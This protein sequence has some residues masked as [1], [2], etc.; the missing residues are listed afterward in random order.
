M[1]RRTTSFRLLPALA[2]LTMLLFAAG[3]VWLFQ[4]RFSIGDIYAPYSS[5][6]ADLLGTAALHD[7]LA[8]QPGFSVRRLYGPNL[9]L[10][11]GPGCTLFVL[12]SDLKGLYADATDLADLDRFLRAGGRVVISCRPTSPS[13]FGKTAKPPVPATPKPET[14]P[15]TKPGTKPETK[16][17]T[18]SGTKPGDT[19]KE[20][21]GKKKPEVDE[22]EEMAAA[23]LNSGMKEL[24]D[25]YGF[26]FVRQPLADLGM[27]VVAE[28]AGEDLPDELAWHGIVGIEWKKASEWR[29][30]Y[31]ASHKPVIAERR[32]GNGM[33]VLLADSWHLS[34]EALSIDR[35]SDLLAWLVGTRTH[36]VL[37]EESHLGTERHEGVM[38]LIRRYRMV[39]VL[40]AFAA[41]ALLYVWR[42]AAGGLRTP[43]EAEDAL[44]VPTGQQTA[45]GLL[46]LLKRNIP[47]GSLLRTCIEQWAADQGR[48]AHPGAAAEAIAKLSAG[49]D[50]DPSLASRYRTICET[51]KKRH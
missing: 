30:L 40:L 7:A 16:P 21:D 20:T 6:R 5:L 48:Q 44:T 35:Q 37:F 24:G 25:V 23:L 11:E 14:K 51:L 45:A 22:A 19:K 1:T 27:A 10:P 50:Q 13:R 34:N 9:K 36:T 38:S 42:Q 18:K 8:L 12:G 2:G 49:K 41:V 28:E 26:H 29:T 17:E 31:A 47:A 33:L 46:H 4:L 32:I 39:W 3:I 15:E 43:E